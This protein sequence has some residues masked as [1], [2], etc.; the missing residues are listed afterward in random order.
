MIIPA[1]T[2]QTQEFGN[3]PLS[4]NLI[5]RL[6]SRTNGKFRKAEGAQDDHVRVQN[7]D[8]LAGMGRIAVLDLQDAQRIVRC[9]SFEWMDERSTGAALALSNNHEKTRKSSQAMTHPIEDTRRH[10]YAEQ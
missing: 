10:V 8:E 4:G 2:S 9:A 3:R 1:N 7:Q 6:T 5:L